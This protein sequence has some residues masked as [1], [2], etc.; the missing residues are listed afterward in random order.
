MSDGAS[1]YECTSTTRSST[2]SRAV[3]ASSAS[4]SAASGARSRAR[5][6]SCRASAADARTAST[7]G[8]ELAARRRARARLASPLAPRHGPQ[9]RRSAVV[10]CGCRNTARESP[11]SPSDTVRR[12]A[13]GANPPRNLSG[14][15][16]VRTRQLW[17]APATPGEASPTEGEALD[18]RP[19]PVAYRGASAVRATDPRPTSTHAAPF[20]APPHRPDA[21]TTQQRCSPPLGFEL[22]RRADG[23]RG[24]GRH[25]RRRAARPAAGRDRG[26]GAPPSCARS[27]AATTPCEPMIGLG[28]HGTH[29][30]GRHPAQRA[31]GPGLVHRLHAV[32]AGDLPG[33]ARGAAELP[34]DGRRPDRAADRQRVAAR[35]GHR[36]RRGD[37]AGARAA[38]ARRPA[39][40]SSTPTRCRRRSR[41]CRPGPRRWA[42]RS[43]SPTSP[44]GCRRLADGIVRRPACSTRAPTARVLDP[45]PAD[46]RGP[47]AR[48]RWPWSPPTCSP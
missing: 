26:A 22:A 42:S 24:A 41:S 7:A 6:P 27:P 11:T 33:P 10:A 3:R 38:T 13:E 35:R 25:P 32:P 31:G 23:R 20:V 37:D 28:Y 46:R 44:T 29:H 4:P 17:S 8:D 43:S 19:V 40:S 12:G 30:P 15:R 9:L 5:S 45:R 18:V 47:R 34:D 1:V 48:R 39:R 2:C 14:A 16:T 36:R 21:R